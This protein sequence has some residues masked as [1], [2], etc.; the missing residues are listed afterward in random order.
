[1]CGPDGIMSSILIIVAGLA[2]AG[3]LM[4]VERPFENWPGFKNGSCVLI[5][6]G[7]RS[8]II[9]LLSKLVYSLKKLLEHVIKSSKI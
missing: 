7:E 5:V 9:V 4:V 6:C 3:Q 1:M 8:F 2:P